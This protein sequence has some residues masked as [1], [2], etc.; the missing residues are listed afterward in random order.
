MNYLFESKEHL[1]EIKNRY[2]KRDNDYLRGELEK[3][4]FLANAATLMRRMID[5]HV[6]PEKRFDYGVDI[7]D[8]ALR[9]YKGETK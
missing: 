9:E 5:R 2:L 7:F 6:I 1:F 8:Q 3:A 4:D